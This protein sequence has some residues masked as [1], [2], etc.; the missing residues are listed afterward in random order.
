MQ[1]DSINIDEFF[2][3]KMYLSNIEHMVVTK[4]QRWTLTFGPRP[5]E[6]KNPSKKPQK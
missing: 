3:I 6:V 2:Y 4:S 5:Y 1:R